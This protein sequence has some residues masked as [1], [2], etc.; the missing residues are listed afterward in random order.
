LPGKIHACDAGYEWFADSDETETESKE[1]KKEVK[2]FTS[3][4][5]KKFALFSLLSFTYFDCG[6]SA[7]PDPALDRPTPPPDFAC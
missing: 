2:E 3:P 5:Y 7:L 6:P 1:E 4:T